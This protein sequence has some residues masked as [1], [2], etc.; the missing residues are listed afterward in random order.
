MNRSRVHPRGPT[1][2]TALIEIPPDIEAMRR[3]D[4]ALAL[5]WRYALRSV[6]ASLMAD[7]SWQ[8]TGFSRSGCYLLDRL[9]V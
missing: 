8:I 9:S 1:I 3:T 2:A 5:R 4:S 7:K 6:M